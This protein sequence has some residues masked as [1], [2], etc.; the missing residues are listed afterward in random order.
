MGNYI[1]SGE[2]KRC[3]RVVKAF[4][5]LYR[6]SDIVV[7]NCGVYGFVKLDAYLPGEGFDCATTYTDSKALFDDL[8]DSWLCNE[9]FPLVHKYNRGYD[10]IYER[11]PER[12]KQEYINKRAYFAKKAKLAI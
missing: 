4:G 6:Q 11:L 1:T 12:K 5:R 10:E 3:R 2:R 9:L 7:K 8:W